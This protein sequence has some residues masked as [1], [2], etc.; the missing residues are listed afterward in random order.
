MLDIL[1][2]ELEV[3]DYI[4]KPE[5]HQLG[6]YLGPLNPNNN[7]DRISFANITMYRLCFKGNSDRRKVV[8]ITEEQ[9][10]MFCNSLNQAEYITE[11]RNQ[12]IL[13]Q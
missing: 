5:S 6:I 2:Q 9:M 4:I 13:N 10:I 3:G 8:K 7:P 1:N 12:I 11:Q